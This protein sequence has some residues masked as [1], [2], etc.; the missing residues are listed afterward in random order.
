MKNVLLAELLRSVKCVEKLRGTGKWVVYVNNKFYFYTKSQT[1]IMLFYILTFS[2]LCF[3]FPDGA[4]YEHISCRQ[5]S[6]T[7]FE[8]TSIHLLQANCIRR[9]KW[10][11]FHATYIFQ[12][13]YQSKPIRYIQEKFIKKLNMYI[14]PKYYLRSESTAGHCKSTKIFSVSVSGWFWLKMSKSIHIL[15]S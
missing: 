14:H 3:H 1:C 8:V 7:K 15:Y 4:K 2:N 11:I 6:K 9:H 13:R 10:I 12:V 5:L